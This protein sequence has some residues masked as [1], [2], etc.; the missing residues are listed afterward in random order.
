LKTEL[1]LGAIVRGGETVFRLFA[2]RARKATLYLARDHQELN[3][4]QH[5]ALARR[6]DADGAA[7]VWEVMLDQNLHGW[8][9]WYSIDGVRERGAETGFDPAMRVLD[10][11]A[12]ATVGER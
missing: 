11:Y 3:A 8:F 2:P 6:A 9:Y 12:L 7:G 1:P 4:A 5:F 10:P